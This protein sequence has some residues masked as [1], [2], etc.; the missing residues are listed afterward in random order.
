MDKSN[1][2]PLLNCFYEDFYTHAMTLQCG[3]HAIHIKT[4]FAQWISDGWE[5]RWERGWEINRDECFN[6]SRFNAVEE[7]NPLWRFCT[8]AASGELCVCVSRIIWS[9]KRFYRSENHSH[10][11]FWCTSIIFEANSTITRTYKLFSKSQ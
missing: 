1:R 11:V 4:F 8:A 3:I 2:F 6:T 5:W 7:K 9:K 10:I